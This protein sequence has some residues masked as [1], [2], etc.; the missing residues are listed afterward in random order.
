MKNKK[1][2]FLTDDE[3]ISF[4]EKISYSQYT[5]KPHYGNM[6]YA[7]IIILVD[8]HPAS[9]YTGHIQEVS[10]DVHLE[11]KFIFSVS[12]NRTEQFFE[13]LEKIK[14]REMMSKLSYQ[15]SNNRINEFPIKFDET[16]ISSKKE[17]QHKILEREFTR[18]TYNFSGKLTSI[19]GYI[20][21]ITETI[22][23][24]SEIWGYDE[25]GKE[26]CLLKYP[27]GSIVS[28]VKDKSKDYLVLEYEFERTTDN[29]HHVYYVCCEMLN[30]DSPVIQYGKTFVTVE[31]ELCF[32][33]NNRIDD[34][35]N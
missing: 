14:K 11:Y 29:K 13:I 28:D 35:L 24:F 3:I 1:V 10:S 23:Y 25:D 33:R 31:D 21:C 32:S 26:H 4:N 7:N 15:D 6:G 5:I 22:N 27:I 16:I 2:R 30:T 20:S 9:S 12:S 18:Y 17:E 19:L 34:I 8:K